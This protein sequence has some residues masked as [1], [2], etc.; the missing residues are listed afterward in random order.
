MLR[1]LPAAIFA[2]VLPILADD[3]ADFSVAPAATWQR[4]NPLG[5]AVYDF[6][7]GQCRITCAPPSPPELYYQV[8]PARGAILAPTEFGD[9]VA[10]VDVT[11]WR[12]TND[13]ATESLFIG[14][15]TRVQSPAYIGNVNCYGLSFLNMGN[16]TAKLQ[17]DLIQGEV[18]ITPLASV[19]FPLDPTRDYRLVL[20]SRGDI[21]TG[22]IFDLTNP[23]TPVAEITAQD[24]SFAIGRCGISASTDRYTTVD[25]TFDNFLAW[26]G[27]PPPL[28]IQPGAAPDTIELS[29]DLRRAMATRLETTT[30]LTQ[31]VDFW[32]PAIPQSSA[33]SGEQL[34]NTFSINGPSRFFRR[35]SL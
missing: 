19:D 14:V 31:A 32:Q 27:T 22:R 11:D 10:S 13:R 26:D 28:A 21:H 30:D 18:Y 8:G 3:V 12:L 16:G 29:C 33:Q 4:H 23:A 17:L 24:D 2:T 5:I 6:S 1:I 34:V 9:V 35:K 20:S 25:A 15:V 7:G